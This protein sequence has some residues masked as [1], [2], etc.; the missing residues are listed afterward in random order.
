MTSASA[1][2]RISFFASASAGAKQISLAPL[3]LIRSIEPGGDW[4]QAARDLQ[5]VLRAG[6]CLVARE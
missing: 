6:Q 1:P 3:F 5:Q 4:P 2:E